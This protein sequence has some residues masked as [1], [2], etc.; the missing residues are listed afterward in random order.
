MTTQTVANTAEMMALDIQAE[1][2]GLQR[3]DPRVR[4]R[5]DENTIHM[6]HTSILTGQDGAEFMRTWWMV[7]IVGDAEP[8]DCMIEIP[9]KL[10]NRLRK[11][12]VTGS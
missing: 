12:E 1:Q 4:A 8:V 10:F 9:L 5:L 11:V 3:L 6:M 7:G 2:L